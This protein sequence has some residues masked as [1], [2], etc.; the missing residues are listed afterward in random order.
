MRSKFAVITATNAIQYRNT[1][2][3]R[4]KQV[5]AGLFH[6]VL[7]IF[8]FENS[9]TGTDLRKAEWRIHFTEKGRDV[10]RMHSASHC[11]GRN[12]LEVERDEIDK[13]LL[14]MIAMKAARAE[15]SAPIVSPLRSMELY[16]SSSNINNSTT[17]Q[18]ET[19]TFFQEWKNVSTHSY[20]LEYFSC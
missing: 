15:L 16:T 4:L 18:S 14:K 11:A 2:N 9:D 8:D 5:S 19:L 1:T 12:V 10:W 13:V 3:L 20:M 7:S 17:L 6:F